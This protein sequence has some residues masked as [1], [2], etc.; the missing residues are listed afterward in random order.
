MIRMI[1]YKM[2]E[3]YT[4][5]SHQDMRETLNGLK[6]EQNKLRKQLN[7]TRNRKI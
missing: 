3:D 2:Y 7:E 1:A 5:H 6:D 4:S